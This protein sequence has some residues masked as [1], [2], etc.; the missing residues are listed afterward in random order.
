MEGFHGLLRV[1][2][3]FVDVWFDVE[4]YGGE[5]SVPESGHVGRIP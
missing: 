5:H 4:S 1:K 2:C 3:L